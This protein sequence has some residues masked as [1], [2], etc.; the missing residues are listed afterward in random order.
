VQIG[1]H[2]TELDLE[3]IFLFV[4]LVSQ[5]FP[6]MLFLEQAAQWRSKKH[7]TRNMKREANVMT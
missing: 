7:G 5:Q 6:F 3:N 2:D 4:P 1:C